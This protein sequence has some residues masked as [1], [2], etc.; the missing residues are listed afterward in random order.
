LTDGVLAGDLAS[1]NPGLVLFSVVSLWRNG[2][3]EFRKNS[4]IVTEG[5]G[6]DSFLHNE[7]TKNKTIAL[8]RQDSTGVCSVQNCPP[9]PKLKRS[10]RV[11]SI[12]GPHFEGT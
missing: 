2:F 11:R 6:R 8:V 3:S 7:T 1:D 5:T 10:E 4:A 9:T 12:N